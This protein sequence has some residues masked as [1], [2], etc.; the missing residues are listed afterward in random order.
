MRNRIGIFPA[1]I[2]SAFVFGGI[3][4]DKGGALMLMAG[5]GPVL[6]IAFERTRSLLPSM[7]AHGLWNGV[8]FFVQ[9]ALFYS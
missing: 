3:H 7:I 5:V 1:V 2:V 8:A 6:A 4:F 9:L